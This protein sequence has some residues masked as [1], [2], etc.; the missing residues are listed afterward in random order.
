MK[1][2]SSAGVLSGSE[3]SMSVATSSPEELGAGSCEGLAE[4]EW[5]GEDDVVVPDREVSS[6]ER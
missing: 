4:D 6:C 2:S 3:V 1:A 5:V